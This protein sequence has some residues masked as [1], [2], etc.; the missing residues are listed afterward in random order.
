MI[1]PKCGGSLTKRLINSKVIEQCLMCNYSEEV[2]KENLK[3]NLKK[4]KANILKEYID[5]DNQKL[6]IIL[7]LKKFRTE[8]KFTQSNMSNILDISAQRYGAIER[9]EN[10]IGIG[11]LVELSMVYGVKVNDLLEVKLISNEEYRE[12]GTY[13][14]CQEINHKIPVLKKDSKLEEYIDRIISI[15]SRLKKDKNNKELSEELKSLKLELNNYKKKKSAL[16]MNRDI[17]EYY[18]YKAFLELYNK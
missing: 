8:N 15:N 10:E 14:I 6:I 12:L 13:V 3:E 17:I 9:C 1:C 18:R 4:K 11:R 2:I 16:L 5:T 7:K